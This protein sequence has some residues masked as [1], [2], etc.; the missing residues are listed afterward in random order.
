MSEAPVTPFKKWYATH[1]GELAEKRKKKYREDIQYREQVKA[2][3]AER[4]ALIRG[5]DKL[6]GYDLTFE[7]V[8]EDI[9]VTVF[10]LREWRRQGDF[11]EPYSH[12]G[13]FWF[14]AAQVSLLARLAEF[15]Q[16]HPRIGH[17][18]AAEFDDLKS[19]ILVNW[20]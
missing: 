13:K 4:R 18:T 3:S 17:R 15:R 14:S 7:R 12:G 10:Q 2:R 1:S 11:P 5:P 8:A 20:S 19:L 6:Y 9:G 16:G